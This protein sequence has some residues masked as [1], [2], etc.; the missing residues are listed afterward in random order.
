MGVLKWSVFLYYYIWHLVYV[1]LECQ[2]N[3]ITFVY[4]AMAV[5]HN[6][7]AI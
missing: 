3:S 6:C 4:T 7:E 2:F 5:I 1:L